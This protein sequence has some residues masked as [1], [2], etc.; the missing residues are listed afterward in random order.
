MLVIENYKK[1][2][3]LKFGEWTCGIAEE[4]G[5]VYR[6]SFHIR[7][8][9]QSYVRWTKTFWIEVER[10]VFT[11]SD[12]DRVVALNYPNIK[13]KNIMSIDWMKNLHNIT[14]NFTEIIQKHVGQ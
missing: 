2:E 5:P 3:G 7:D 6:F 11:D 10:N 1:L 8:Y 14:S 9:N 13:R 4:H 12:G